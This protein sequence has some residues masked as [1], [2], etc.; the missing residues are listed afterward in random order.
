MSQEEELCWWMLHASYTYKLDSL[1]K[2]CRAQERGLQQSRKLGKFPN[3]FSSA[4]C[5]INTKAN[6]KKEAQVKS[7]RRCLC[8]CEAEAATVFTSDWSNPTRKTTELHANTPKEESSPRSAACD[9]LSWL[10]KHSSNPCFSSLAT[11]PYHVSSSPH[12][13]LHVNNAVPPWQ[14]LC[15]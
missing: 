5:K 14:F 15:I 3:C 8:W 9:L 2:P 10:T 7:V 11:Q 13:N 12:L 4:G 1:L 6:T